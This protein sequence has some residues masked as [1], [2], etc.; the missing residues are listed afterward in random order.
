VAKSETPALP[1]ATIVAASRERVR[2]A[3]ATIVCR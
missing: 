1:Q 2:R 3:R